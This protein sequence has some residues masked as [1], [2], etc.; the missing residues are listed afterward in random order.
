MESNMV[1]RRMKDV[2]DVYVI[3]HYTC[4]VISGYVYMCVYVCIPLDFVSMVHVV[5][6]RYDHV[7]PSP[8][9]TGA[10]WSYLSHPL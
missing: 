8:R 2:E 3:E 5:A 10:I 4:Q 6:G 9:C 1:E 7:I